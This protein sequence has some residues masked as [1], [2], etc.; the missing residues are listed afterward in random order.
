MKQKKLWIIIAIIVVAVI[1]TFF[2]L[3]PAPQSTDPHPVVK[4][5]ATL[6]L[7]GNF[8]DIGYSAKVAL[9]AAVRDANENSN[10]KFY[11]ELLMEND[12]MNS[13]KTMTIVS[14]FTEYDKVSAIV[15]IFSMSGRVI[16]PVATKDKIV[17]INCGYADKNILSSKYNF[18]NFS[19]LDSQSAALFE[20]LKT[21]GIKKVSFLF[22]NVGAS[23]EILDRLIPLLQK[24]GI[25]FDSQRFNPG[26]RDFQQA[27]NKIKLD[28]SG[29]LLVYAFEPEADIIAKEVIKQKLDKKISFID[30]SMMSRNLELFDGTYNIGSPRM[31]EEFNKRVGLGSSNGYIAGY[32]YDIGTVIVKAIE[33]SAA[34]N[35]KIPTGDEIADTILNMKDFSGVVG[36]YTITSNGQFYSPIKIYLI[37]DGEYI[38]TK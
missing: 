26:E 30:S 8:G 37:K 20:F 16:A 4:I 5:G 3:R 21:N 34:D 9:S 33:E 25:A 14:K 11:Y 12:E 15:S 18:A 6:P 28:N 32:M 24:N 1:A 27:V 36:D 23:Q 35:S 2:A 7:S 31:S 38:E 17:H 13:S 22:S 19:P 29:A 10:N